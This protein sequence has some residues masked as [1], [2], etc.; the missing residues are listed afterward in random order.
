MVKIA[1]PRKELGT[2]YTCFSCGAKFYDLHR[3]VPTC[4]K[5]DADQRENPELLQPRQA[6]LAVKK[7]PPRKKPP[8]PV[9]PEIV[10]GDEAVDDDASEDDGLVASDLDD[11]FDDEEIG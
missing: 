3:P 4:P 8:P 6:P 9:E 10:G 11:D 7:A 1:G 2:R 5:C